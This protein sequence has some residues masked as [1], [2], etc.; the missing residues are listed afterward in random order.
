MER[1]WPF[2]SRDPI[3]PDFRFINLWH[4][5]K[6][7]SIFFPIEKL[8][9]QGEA[10]FAHPVKVRQPIGLREY[11]D[12]EVS[13]LNSLEEFKAALRE[14]YNQTGLRVDWSVVDEKIPANELPK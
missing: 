5:W 10:F 14:L 12:R 7:V 8:R 2:S 6:K 4:Q 11:V 3:W 9:E 13:P 1:E